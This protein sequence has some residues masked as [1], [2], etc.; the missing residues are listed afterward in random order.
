MANDLPR[1][2]NQPTPTLTGQLSLFPTPLPELLTRLKVSRDE[3][4]RWSRAG[5]ISFTP[6]TEQRLEP[7]EINEVEFVAYVVRSGL[8]DDSI[9]LLLAQ[10]VP[11]MNYSQTQVVYSFKYGWV[12]VDTWGHFN[13][14]FDEVDDRV[15][16]WLELH[17]ESEEKE[18]VQSL[19][20]DL[21]FH[22]G[23]LE[24]LGLAGDKKDDIS[25]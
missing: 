15:Y 20:S 2:F 13:S 9:D 21:R 23:T 1:W 7:S 18:I 12:Q 24:E 19:W 6:D 5:W 10:L 17:P 22:L 25:T 16:E 11:P 14:P 4:L 3:L 8:S